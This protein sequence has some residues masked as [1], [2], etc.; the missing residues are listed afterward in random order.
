MN[1]KTKHIELELPY[2]LNAQRIEYGPY[3]AGDGFLI[4][5]ISRDPKD[6]QAKAAFVVRAC[7]NHHALM[8]VCKELLDIVSNEATLNPDCNYKFAV[9]RG[10][11]AIA[12]AEK[13]A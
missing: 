10:L 8:K 6:W 3:V 7:N 4:A 12:L 2:R 13:G 9:Q 11:D 1:M 5:T